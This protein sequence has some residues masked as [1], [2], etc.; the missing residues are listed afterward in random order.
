MSILRSKTTVT[1]TAPITVPDAPEARFNAASALHQSALVHY[2]EIADQLAEAHA[3]YYTLVSELDAEI[4]RLTKLRSESL[5]RGD[6]AKESARSILD[7][8][9]GFRD[10]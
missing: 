1:D 7:L 9:R 4:E 3:R 8:T 10:E 6:Q 5:T 2:H